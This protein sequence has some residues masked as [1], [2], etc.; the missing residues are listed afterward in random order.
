MRT[1]ILVTLVVLV[2]L[3]V[4]VLGPIYDGWYGDTVF[5]IAY[6]VAAVATFLLLMAIAL[7][8]KQD[9]FQ[10]RELISTSFIIV[11]LLLVTETIFFHKKLP[12]G[13]FTATLISNFTT[14]TGVVVGAYFGTNAV[15]KFAESR[16]R[17]NEDRHRDETEKAD[18]KS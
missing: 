4:A 6:G 3:A 11:Y 17:S 2:D 10:F 18:G 13:N 15:E 9:R 5:E 7:D 16:A 12:E 8:P 14:L 1:L